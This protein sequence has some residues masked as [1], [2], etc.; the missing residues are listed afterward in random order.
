MQ[1]PWRDFRGGVTARPCYGWQEVEG[2]AKNPGAVPRVGN[3]PEVW[4]VGAGESGVAGQA[5]RATLALVGTV[6]LVWCIQR[7]A[8]GAPC[9]RCSEIDRTWSRSSS[10]RT[11]K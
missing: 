3:T 9:Q 8:S 11:S 5:L 1:G 6:R 7:P 4:R 2:A 10:S